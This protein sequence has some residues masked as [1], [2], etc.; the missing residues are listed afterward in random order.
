MSG[1]STRRLLVCSQHCILDLSS[2]AALESR[3]LLRLLRPLGWEGRIL[4]GPRLDSQDPVSL[5]AMLLRQGLRWIERTDVSGPLPYAM[6]ET[7]ADGVPATVYAPPSFAPEPTYEEGT[8][9]LALLDREFRMH[10]PDVMLTYGGNWV[11]RGAIE[12]AIHHGVPVC[13]WLRNTLYAGDWLF[14]GV[15]KVLVPSEFTREFYRRSIGLETVAIHPIIDW[16]RVRCATVQG[17]YVTY[18][19]PQPEKGVYLFARLAQVMGQ[20]RPDIPFLVVLGRGAKGWL[21]HTGVDL[22]AA[23][24]DVMPTTPDP[25]QFFALSKLVIVPSL[26]DETFGRVA[27]EAMINGIPV[28]ASRRGGLPETLAQAGYLFDV[29]ARYTEH[30]REVPTA[31]EVLPWAET[32][33]RLW[34]DAELYATEQSRCLAAAEQWRPEVVAARY[35]DALRSCLE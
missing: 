8:P 11:G 15:S 13:F 22:E 14:Q 35:D 21:R 7:V 19:N 24:F 6:L 25:R 5:S 18:V 27:A 32:I 29:P 28:L 20:R 23:N 33:E 26:W 31:D 10:R 12:R 30:T 17:K 3:E 1:S 16:E 2:G 9:F 34:D 4:C